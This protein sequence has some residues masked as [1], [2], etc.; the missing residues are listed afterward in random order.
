MTE[1]ELNLLKGKVVIIRTSIEEC[2]K[3]VINRW[4][5]TNKN[6]N[7]EELEKYKNKKI[8]MFEWYKSLNDFI[9][10]LNKY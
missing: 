9:I 7:E 3:R 1:K 10:N 6:Y 5:E 8:G 4:K 2:Y